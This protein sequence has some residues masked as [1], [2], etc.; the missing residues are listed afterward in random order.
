M[1]KVNITQRR[2][3]TTR[4]PSSYDRIPP[5][6]HLYTPR[7]GSKASKVKRPARE[8]NKV[9]TIPTITQDIIPTT[10]Q[11]TIPIL[12]QDIVDEILDH[13]AADSDFQSLQACALVS[14]SWIR[15]HHPRYLFHTVIITPKNVGRWFKRFPVPEESP[16]R[17]VSDLRVLIGAWGHNIPDTFLE[18]IWWF[19]NVDR[20]SFWG[21]G[22]S[23]TLRGGSLWRLPESVTSL[24]IR[25]GVL[26]LAHV[27]DAMAQLPNLDDLTLSVTQNPLF[28]VDNGLGI[29]KVLKG[30][31]RGKLVLHDG[32]ISEDVVNM[33][34]EIPS[35]LHFTEVEIKCPVRQ[36]LPLAVRLAEACGE[37]LAKLSYT[38]AS[39]S[40]LN[41]FPMSGWI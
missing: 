26:T 13:L 10:P 14:K 33:L 30:R 25:T 35:G 19:S 20:L 8:K 21:Y 17:H 22:R 7:M 2:I 32:A 9:V 34:L 4:A 39:D 23:E 28:W 27:H 18:Y 1:H 38:E 40:K 24:T 3:G 31:F 36:Y 37:T 6:T 5:A 12:P 16:A 11:I 15:S 41:S 29:G